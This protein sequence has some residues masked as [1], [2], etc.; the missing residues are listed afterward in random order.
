MAEYKSYTPEPQGGK[1]GKKG[2]KGDSLA[3]YLPLLLGAGAGLFLLN[4]SGMLGGAKGCSKGNSCK[5][6]AGCVDG[7]CGKPVQTAQVKPNA[8]AGVVPPAGV[9]GASIQA[10]KKETLAK[11][12][13]GDI[14][15]KK[16]LQNAPI[17]Q[18]NQSELPD[19]Q[20]P[21]K[22]G[23][24]PVGQYLNNGSVLNQPSIINADGQLKPNPA[25]ANLFD[26][27]RG[28]FMQQQLGPIDLNLQDEER[29][30]LFDMYNQQQNF[31]FVDFGF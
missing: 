16:A 2:K 11:A 27:A 29:K 15:A 22:A 17:A 6:G 8:Q 14:L 20:A 23:I 4:K 5:G 1:G 9:V 3:K 25:A 7:Q 24:M 18:Q 30:K 12:A 21:Q 13:A 10:D 19:L 26:N 28:A 31:G